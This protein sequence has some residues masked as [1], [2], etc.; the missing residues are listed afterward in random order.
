MSGEDLDRSKAPIEREDLLRLAELAA[1]AEE[2]L[3][4]RNPQSSGR[5]T[6]RLLGRALCQGAALHYVNGSSGAKSPPAEPAPPKP[7]R[8]D[9][10]S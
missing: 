10:Q 9:R 6:G 8:P 4:L 3:F 5:Y 2:E 7:W 1:E